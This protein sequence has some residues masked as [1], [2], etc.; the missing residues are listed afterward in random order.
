M[1]KVIS[2]LV[3]VLVLVWIP[4]GV[5]AQQKVTLSG[6][7]RD[8]ANGENL[9]AASVYVK[10]LNT[11]AKTNNYGFYSLTIPAGEYN[12]RFTYIG[13]ETKWVK[14][15]VDKDTRLNVE[16]PQRGY[17]TK[18]VVIKDTRKDENVK[19]TDMG[20]VKLGMEQVKALPVVFGETDILK[21]LQLTPGV[22]SGGEGQSGIYV[23]GGGPD[24]NL[25]L[26]DEAVVYNPGHL[27]GFF[28]VFNPDAVK[29]ISLTKGPMAANYGGRLSS[30]VD[31]T[32]R[33]GNN[34]KYQVEGG[35]GLISSRL[36]VQGPIVKDKGSFIITGRRTYIDAVSSLFIGKRSQ[37]AGGI[38]YR[39]YDVNAKLNYKFSDKDR[40]YLSGY[41]GKD[42]FDFTSAERTFSAKIPWG[43]T[44]GT[45]RWNHL[46][47][48][49]L[50]VNTTLVYND[51]NF[52]FSAK[53][54]DFDIKLS[55]GIRD[56]NA[57]VDFDYFSSFKHKFK[58]GGAYTYHTFI[59][60]TVSGKS[61]ETA[62]D[63]GDAIKKF[64]H[65][66]GV[67]LMDEFEPW[68]WL[69]VNAGLRYSF[70]VQ[71]GPYTEYVYDGSKKIDSTVFGPGAQV[72]TF[73]GLEPR[74][75]TRISLD[76]QTS[77]K[78]GVARTNQ[79][80]H[81]VSNNGTTLPTDLWIPSTGLIQPQHAWQY[82]A[83]A[84]RNFKDNM[85]ETSV[86]VYYKKMENLVEYRNGYIPSSIR[87][88]EYDLV[89]GNG[90]AYGAE[91]FL[92]K[93]KGRW[94]GWIG[95]T[96]A[97]TYRT[98]PDLNYGKSYPAKY[99]RRHDVSVVQS[100]ELNKKWRLS[101]VF[102]YSSG[103]L[104]TLPTGFMTI[105]GQLVP[106]YDQINNYRLPAYH[107]LDLAAVYTPKR[108]MF[109]KV[110]NSFTFSVYNVYSRMNPY[111]FYPEYRGDVNKGYEIKVKS[112]SIFPILPSVTWDFK[113]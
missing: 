50:F 71:T 24:Q 110:T 94:T 111:F 112:V 80:I 19:S 89:R 32:M 66:G 109:K 102:V 27:F 28:S 95:Y 82:S 61:G 105:N 42:L 18:E 17:E 11:G 21:A 93:G 76:P 39:F 81:L 113:F 49:K 4:F 33:E 13:Y 23:R 68:P 20:M 8:M 7:M 85:F 75:T 73:G 5:L 108:K 30:V 53:Q 98:F 16:L 2:G 3:T 104:V 101:A 63:P 88:V 45:L 67:Y 59:P 55:S 44:T 56:L 1:Q 65:E 52:S 78:L 31:V 62:F 26:L 29:D 64:A 25:L 40:V 35:L 15:S 48:D 6:Y 97:W 54:N 99:D 47:N 14:M 36:A 91:F 106:I 100:Y 41:F 87:D 103:N 74:L 38:P 69:E 34:K 10:E 84:F 77:L 57:K 70:F 46:F 9:V 96:L 22:K 107:R 12:F 83:G 72:A 37:L 79:Y 60:N 58:F 86:E 51:Y 43:N 90:E 92:N